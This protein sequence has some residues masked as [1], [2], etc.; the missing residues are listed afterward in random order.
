MPTLPRVIHF[1]RAYSHM[2]TNFPVTFTLTIKP[3]N[4]SS[5]T[6][7]GL[8][9]GCNFETKLFPIVA[10]IFDPRIEVHFEYTKKLICIQQ[11]K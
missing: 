10:S 5:W 2:N 3:V 6:S 7:Q 8:L 11:C 1:P 9:L 4:L